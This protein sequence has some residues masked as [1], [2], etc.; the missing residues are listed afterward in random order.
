MRAGGPSDRRLVLAVPC[1]PELRTGGTIYDRRLAEGLRARGWRVDWLRLPDGFPFPDGAVRAES[2]AALAALP[3]G[4]LLLL[5]GLALGV[6]PEAA[7]RESRRLRLLG[8]V[9]HP[10]GYE[11]GLDPATAARLVASERA[12]LCWPRRILCTSPTTARTLAAEFDVVPERITVIEPGTDPAPLARGSGGPELRLLA[13]GS[14]IPRK[15]FDRL[16]RLLAGL[17]ALAW[18]LE[19]VGALDRSAEAG[20]ALRDA[21]A[22]TGLADRIALAGELRG[23]ALDAAF[24]R[25]DLFVSASGY[26]G[27]GMALAEA[28]ARGLP[29]VATAGGAV[30]DWLPAEAALLVPPE[31]E[32]ALAG[33]LA[34]AIGEPGV[35]ARL[36]EGAIAARARLPRWEEQTR[37]AEAVLRAELER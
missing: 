4:T 13:V 21:I 10:L 16:V 18:R 11:E 17:R 25:A 28:L 34:R 37:R 22:T 3:D 19:I 32:A 29:I 24:D 1:D 5:D 9:H 23:E 8:L 6:L 15:R 36:R 2:E 26:E 12:A 33:A 7:E 30:A 20:A 31:D 14:V 35:R 27:Y